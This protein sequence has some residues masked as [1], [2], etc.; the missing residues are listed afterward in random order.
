MVSYEIILSVLIIPILIITESLNFLDI[1]YKQS[2]YG[3]F[4]IPLIPIAIIFFISI[5]AETNR[6]PFD[7]AESESE[8]VGGYNIEYSAISFAFF[9]FSR[10]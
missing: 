6:A 8:V 4:F 10:V 1:I 2:I 3:I 5:L 9:L 7:L